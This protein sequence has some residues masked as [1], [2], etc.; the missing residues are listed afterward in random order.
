MLSRDEGQRCK[1]QQ[2]V[3]D[4]FGVL[5]P[6]S[7]LQLTPILEA[8]QTQIEDAARMFSKE[9]TSHEEGISIVHPGER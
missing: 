7:L 3:R 6:L 5:L 2:V 9:A 4:R 8:P 1:G